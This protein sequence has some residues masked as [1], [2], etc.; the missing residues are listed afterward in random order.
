MGTTEAPNGVIPGRFGNGML[1]ALDHVGIAV[2]D[3]DEAVSFYESAFGAQLAYRERVERDGVEEAMLTIGDSFVQLLTPT[4]D[5]SAVAKW[6][7]RHGP[8]LHHVGYRVTD[9]EQAQSRAVSAGAR[10]IDEAPRPGSRGTTVVFLHPKTAFGT[11]IELVQQS[12]NAGER[13]GES[14]R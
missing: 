2:Y 4:R 13:T 14:A 8:G 12:E 7:A 5:D 1:T 9:C 6:L 10:S 3:L 11:L